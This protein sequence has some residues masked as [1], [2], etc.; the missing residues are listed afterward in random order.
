MF[1]IQLFTF[2]LLTFLSLV[3]ETTLG[4]CPGGVIK[5][6]SSGSIVLCMVLDGL[7]FRDRSLIAAPSSPSQGQHALIPASPHPLLAQGGTVPPEGKQSPTAAAPSAGGAPR[8]APSLSLVVPCAAQ[9]GAPLD[10]GS[11]ACSQLT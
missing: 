7:V 8:A 1:V 9:A 10:L 6:D 2:C 3:T 11:P 4:L 5:V